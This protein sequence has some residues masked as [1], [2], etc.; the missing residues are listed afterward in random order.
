MSYEY[1]WWDLEDSKFK[2]LLYDSINMYFLE[3]HSYETWEDFCKA[4]PHMAYAYQI[5]TRFD[6][7]EQ[8][9]VDLRVIPQMLGVENIPLSSKVKDINKHDWLKSIADLSLFRFSS[10]RDIAFHFVN[11]VLDLNIPDLKLNIKN[12]NKL[13]KSDHPNIFASLG[14]LENCGKR[15]R[16]ER[17]DRA[18]KGFSN[19]YTDDDQM[20]RS[21][22]S[23]ESYGF[24]SD[25]YDLVN[26]YESSK[27]KIYKMVAKET[28]DAL[29]ASIKLAD[30][31]YIHYR[32]RYEDLSSKSISGLKF[33]PHF[34]L[35]QDENIEDN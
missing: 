14:E 16:V 18:H 11:E 12:L 21:I 20:F 10:I 15:L 7:L 24:I 9:F 28:R 23:A 27:E 33:A 6:A 25:D 8:Q 5:S 4:D 13:L 22:S 31:L 35:H 3:D 34:R 2:G 1:F 17:N 32:N 29:A 19:L 30:D 26:I